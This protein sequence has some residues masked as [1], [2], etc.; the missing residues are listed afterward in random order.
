M[1]GSPPWDSKFPEMRLEDFFARLRGS[2]EEQSFTPLDDIW[3]DS[4]NKLGEEF[5]PRDDS[6]E[7]D[8]SQLMKSTHEYIGQNLTIEIDRAMGSRHPSLA[9]STR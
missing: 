7:D 9:L 5:F 2:F 6:P 8:P 4:L 1:P 3:A